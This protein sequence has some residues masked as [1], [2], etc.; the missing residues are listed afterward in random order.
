MGLA[1]AWMRRSR[2][3]RLGFVLALTG[4]LALS[5]TLPRARVSSAPSAADSGRRRLEA[6]DFAVG[7][8]ELKKYK[9]EHG[10]LVV[11][12]AAVVM[13]DGNEI[14]L[15]KWIQ[16]LRQLHKNTY[17][18]PKA[19]SN[20][21][22]MTSAQKKQLDDLGFTFELPDELRAP[23][24]TDFDAGF[25]ALKSY[26]AEHGDLFVPQS[27]VVQSPDGKEMK[28]G[29]WVQRLRQL[30][31]NTY[32]TPKARKGFGQ[33]TDEQLKQLEEIGFPFE[34]PEDMK[35]PS[36]VEWD[37]AYEQLVEFQKKNK[38]CLVSQATIATLADGSEIKLGK[39][40][41][42]QRQVYKNTYVTAGARKSFGKMTDEQK[43]KLEAIGFEFEV[44]EVFFHCLVQYS[45]RSF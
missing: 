30:H 38:N 43:V 39:W 33:M 8:S 22:Q 23:E 44:P 21:G 10:D 27:S 32:V 24:K 7:L 12:Q 42:R 20:F 26:K 1:G 41:Q 11:P 40:V 37:G 36:P 5:L 25:S 9:A 35:G 29:K 2:W 17:V 28:L 19:R 4:V 6:V 31:K 18:T 15:G 45:D 13:V 3:R 16:R 14:K 34:L